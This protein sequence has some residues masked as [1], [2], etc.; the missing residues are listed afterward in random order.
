[1]PDVTLRDAQ[2][3]LI[4]ESELLAECASCLSAVPISRMV[5]TTVAPRHVCE[6]CAELLPTC[7]ECDQV[8]VGS[9]WA[10][11]TG[12]RIC[13]HHIDGPSYVYETCNRCG[14]ATQAP[15]STEHSGSVCLDCADLY[16]E[17]EG[18]DILITP[19]IHLCDECTSDGAGGDLDDLFG[20]H[21]LIYD[22]AYKPEP[23]FHGTGPVWL[24]LEL[25]VDVYG[26]RRAAAEVANY[27]L[28]QLGYLKDDSSINGFEVVCHP[29]S[30]EWAMAHFPWRLLRDLE[31]HGA[32]VHDNTGIHIHINR[33]GFSDPIHVFRWLKFIYRNER[34]V[35]TISRRSSGEWA[36]FHPSDRERAKHAAKGDMLGNR[37]VAVNT[38][39]PTTFE[40]RVFASS[41]DTQ[42]LKAALAFAAASVEYTRHL[43]VPD[44]IH[45]GWTWAA[46]TEWLAD[47]DEFSPLRAEMEALGCA[48]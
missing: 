10:T 11:D 26:G 40:L 28:G 30:Y 31:R 24:G 35:T 37:H 9:T 6:S 8:V 7:W 2:Q 38:G 19:G 14:Q 5:N 39:N 17:C 1:M 16:T 29:M 15:R 22:Y 27:H 12:H 13:G 42:E 43:K 48:C 44:V 46:F 23:V 4:Q 32:E 25:E 45:G 34:Q 18:C 33:N 41:L 3:A 36:E 20:G 21:R 47:R